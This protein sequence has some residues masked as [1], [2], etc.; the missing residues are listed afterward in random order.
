MII[1]KKELH[2]YF[3][4]ITEK[5]KDNEGNEKKENTLSKPH[6]LA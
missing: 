5:Y 1:T 2:N 3:V 6:N 4:M